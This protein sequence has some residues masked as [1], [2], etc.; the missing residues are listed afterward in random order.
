M[1]I[2]KC[3]VFSVYCF[4]FSFFCLLFIVRMNK[5]YRWTPHS[6]HKCALMAP[7]T[8][9]NERACFIETLITKLKF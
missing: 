9:A 3:L 7:V 5:V 2:V 8:L 6:V 1:F 4:V